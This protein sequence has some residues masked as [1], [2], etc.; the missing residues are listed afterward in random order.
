[1]RR[2]KERKRVGYEENVLTVLTEIG[3]LGSRPNNSMV[4]LVNFEP[5]NCTVAFRW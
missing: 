2:I 5:L 1:M 4:V 3:L